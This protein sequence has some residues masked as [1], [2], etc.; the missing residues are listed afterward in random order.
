[1]Q[2]ARTLVTWTSLVLVALLTPVA[3]V[4][5]WA[6]GTLTETDR[7]VATVAPLAED[8]QVQT[9]VERRLT[10][11][12][13]TAVEDP[14][15][16]ERAAA[17]LE[18]QGVPPTLA[19]ALTLLADPVQARLES[20]VTRVVGRVVQGE[21][22]ADAWAASNEVAHQELVDVLS[23][24]TDLLE[25]DEGDTVSIRIA[26][27]TDA[28]RREL[29][30]AGVPG[31]DRIPQVEAS[32]PLAEVEDLGRAQT[33]YTWL[34]RLGAWLPWLVLVL[35]VVAVLAARGRRRGLGLA[36]LA[37]V[38]G[39]VATVV[40]LAL[41]RQLLLDAVP[42]DTSETVVRSVL[43]MVSAPLR[44][45]IQ[46]TALAALV[47]ALVVAL[48][49]PS[50]AVRRLRSG[51]ARAW[52]WAGAVTA[53]RPWVRLVAA[54]AAVVG[55]VIVVSSGDLGVPVT[56]LLTSVIAL[57]AVVAVRPG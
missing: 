16:L 35:V 9:E 7:Y 5:A 43:D 34:D 17:A 30:A 1:M 13:L 11:R 18:R 10:E 39:S 37:L 20:T 50:P 3:L 45:A 56:L 54:L 22:L 21:A 12:I 41:G 19:Q 51:A 52:A 8:P 31:A 4:A 49:D 15:I 36:A 48:V 53:E 40:L 55:V 28:L 2:S 14:R 42:P 23:G 6:E 38:A 44:D 46:V 29:V 24:E 57:S 47:V 32:F 25:V 33:A 27:L 26:T